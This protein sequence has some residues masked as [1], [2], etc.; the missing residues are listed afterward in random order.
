MQAVVIHETGG[1]EVLRS[2]EVE[3]PEPGDGEVLIRVHAASVNPV[4]WK[5]RRGM[6]EKQLPTGALREEGERLMVSVRRVDAGAWLA[7][8][9][10]AS[11]ELP[12]RIASA[13]ISRVGPGL[14]DAEVALT[15]VGQK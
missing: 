1:P 11:T 6:A 15:P 12:L 5:H 14:V 8:L 9:K 3:P 13:R 2:E 7:W 4:D 10:E